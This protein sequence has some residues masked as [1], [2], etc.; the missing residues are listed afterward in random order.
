[1]AVPAGFVSQSSV[2]PTTTVFELEALEGLPCGCVAAAYRASPGTLRWF[3]SKPRDRP[4][5]S[6]ATAVAKSFDSA[7]PPSLT[8]TTTSSKNS[9]RPAQSLRPESTWPGD[10]QRPEP[11]LRHLTRQPDPSPATFRLGVRIEASKRPVRAA[12]SVAESALLLGRC[13]PIS[14]AHRVVQRLLEISPKILIAYGKAMV[15]F[16]GLEIEE[17]S[18]DG[19]DLS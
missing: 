2:R 1:M 12:N 10:R 4:A 6:P 7:T 16:E 14:P 15:R 9:R 3:H 8:I 13:R 5:S 17:F 19:F 18:L 11:L